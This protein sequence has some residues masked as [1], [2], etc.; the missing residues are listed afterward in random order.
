MCT[1]NVCM[2]CVSFRGSAR[3][4]AKEG[5]GTGAQKSA[6]MGEFRVH[7]LSGSITV[8]YHMPITEA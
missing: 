8:M 2:I 3:T 5:G 4:C 6:D 1:H 7:L